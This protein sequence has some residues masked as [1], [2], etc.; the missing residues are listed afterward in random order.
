MMMKRLAAVSL[1][2][3]F[4]AACGSDPAPPEPS[5]DDSQVIDPQQNLD[6]DCM[7]DLEEIEAGTNPELADSDGDG[8]DDCAELDCVSNPI[9]PAEVCYACGW[10]HND[11][12]TIVPTGS[13]AS[14]VMAEVQ[15]VDQ[16]GDTVSL[17]DFYGAYHIL[18]MTAAW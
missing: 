6:G 15:L 16:C 18:F 2:L 17:W 5:D 14:D 8:I 12:G 13:A 7:T 9:D 10:K 4:A 1:A 11:P 3:L